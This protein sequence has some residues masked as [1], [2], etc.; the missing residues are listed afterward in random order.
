MS[1]SDMMESGRGPGV[2]G[3]LLA[4]VVL[5]GFALL[6]LFVF[7]EGMAGGGRTIESVIREQETE[8]RDLRQTASRMRGDL[9]KSDKRE[10]SAKKLRDT[11]TQNRFKES[12][13]KALA[14]RVVAVNAAITA[15]RTEFEDYKNEYRAFIRGKAKGSELDKL[16]T[17]SG[18]TY[19]SVKVREVTAIGMQVI[20]QDGQKRIPFEDLP[21]DL[22]DLYQFDASQK[23]AAVK[24]ETA[25]F[26]KHVGDTEEAVAQAQAQA[27]KQAETRSMEAREQ[28]VRD[29]RVASA[30]LTSL[31]EDIVRLETAIRHE[32]LKRIS[33]AP[34]MKQ[35]LSAMEK[36]RADLRAEVARLQSLQ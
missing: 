25:A 26:E 1:F 16:V 28:A 8:I 14:D 3:M 4:L 9:E 20:H 31:D 22:Q 30:K 32:S 17:R 29:L 2:I 33:R 15:K 36:A 21:A 24:A 12:E 11:T 35:Q 27:A 34:Q 5:A 13:V 10:S 6:Y 18:V 23:E 19:L 7:D